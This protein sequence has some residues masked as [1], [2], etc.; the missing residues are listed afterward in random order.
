MFPLWSQHKTSQQDKT[1]SQ[2][3]IINKKKRNSLKKKYTH[4]RIVTPLLFTHDTVPE[5][6]WNLQGESACVKGVLKRQHMRVFMYT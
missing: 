6:S 3:G 4:T 5:I 2:C 1:L